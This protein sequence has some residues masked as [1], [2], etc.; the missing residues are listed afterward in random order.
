M[1]PNV[2]SIVRT[3]AMNSS[4]L[5]VLEAQV[6]HVDIGEILEQDALAFHDRLAA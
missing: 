5:P 4:V 6:E 2:G 1:P 3:A